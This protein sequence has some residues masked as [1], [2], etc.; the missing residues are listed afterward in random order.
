MFRGKI[1]NWCN[2]GISLI[3]EG[4]R[5]LNSCLRI[6]TVFSLRAGS[7]TSFLSFRTMEYLLLF[8][9]PRVVLFVQRSTRLLSEWINEWFRGKEYGGPDVEIPEG[10]C[11][12][13][14]SFWRRWQMLTYLRINAV[15]WLSGE[16]GRIGKCHACLLPLPHHNYN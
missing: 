13:L 5:G 4:S 9:A 8:L 12:L 1:Q 15:F 11:C 7:G 16:N 6:N 10:K 2:S 14:T 3:C